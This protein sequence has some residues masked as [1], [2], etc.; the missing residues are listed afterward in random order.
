MQT[1][2]AC[3]S[4]TS[5]RHPSIRLCAIDACIDLAP[6]YQTSTSQS[7]AAIST[8]QGLQRHLPV[9]TLLA[10]YFYST[11]H[12]FRSCSSS[13]QP[14]TV[15]ANH[16]SLLMYCFR[17]FGLPRR[18]SVRPHSSED[19][20]DI[21]QACEP[22]AFKFYLYLVCILSCDRGSMATAPREGNLD[23]SMEPIIVQCNHYSEK[24]RP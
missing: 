2:N 20:N 21:L 19:K 9:Q 3:T 24:K 22:C 7:C 12:I 4:K 18:S 1:C 13:S 8:S 11:V 15:W 23:I 14:A 5:L 16:K 10:G 6:C 17:T